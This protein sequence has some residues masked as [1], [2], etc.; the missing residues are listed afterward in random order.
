M[1]IVPKF[2]IDNKTNIL[3]RLTHDYTKNKLTITV[4]R[5]ISNFI[6]S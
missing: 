4:I 6:M 5:A 1:I 2:L 3:G